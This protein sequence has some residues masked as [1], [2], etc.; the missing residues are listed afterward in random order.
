MGI[1]YFKRYQM[2]LDLSTWQVIDEALPAD[3]HFIS[4]HEDHLEDHAAVKHASFQNEIDAN[5]FPSLAEYESCRRLMQEI[6]RRSNFLADGTWLIAYQPIT[7]EEPEYCGT[8]Q[9]LFDSAQRGAVQ[10]LGIVP[11]HRGLKLGTRL[12]F[13]SLRHFKEM[14]IQRSMLEV[15]AQNVGALRLYKRLGFRIMKTV[16]KPSNVVHS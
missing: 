4:W 10:N 3:Y 7:S 6:T 14:G 1:T 2:E 5:V 9:A 12:L 11:H 13:K 16:Y 8:I 15:T